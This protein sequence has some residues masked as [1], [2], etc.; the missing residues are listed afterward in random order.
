MAASSGPEPAPAARLQAEVGRLL[1]SQ[2]VDYRYTPGGWSVSARGVLTLA[3]GRTVF[4]KL[5]DV[6]DTARALRDEI[7]AYRLL[8]PRPFMPRLI[9]ADPEVPVL[10]VE[11]LSRAV[12]VPPWTERSLRDFHRLCDELASTPAP[13]GLPALQSEIEGDGWERVAL[14]PV[15]A[16]RVLPPAW[17]ERNLPALREAQ[18]NADAEGSSLVHTD[19]RSD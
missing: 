18:R 7:G 19:L 4:A 2:V 13:A 16:G 5:G 14:D 15:V 1:K 10:V 17:L 11:D 8:G 9:A 6:P 12:R 3:G